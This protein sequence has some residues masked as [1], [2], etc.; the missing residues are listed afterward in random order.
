MYNEINDKHF[1]QLQKQFSLSIDVIYSGL[2][3]SYKITNI[4]DRIG[5]LYAANSYFII[6]KFQI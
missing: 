2:I 4:S 1:M 3:I 6:D 5:L